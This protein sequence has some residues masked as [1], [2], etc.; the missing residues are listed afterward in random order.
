MNPAAFVGLRR[1]GCVCA[2][3][4]D[5]RRD[6]DKYAASFCTTLIREFRARGLRVELLPLDEARALPRRCNQPHQPA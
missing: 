1:C 6:A 2:A 5:M 3:V 4:L